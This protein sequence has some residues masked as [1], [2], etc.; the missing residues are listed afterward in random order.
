VEISAPIMG[1]RKITRVY[2]VAVP[3]QLL[4]SVGLDKET[5]VSFALSAEDP[6][7]ICMFAADAVELTPAEGHT[8][9]VKPQ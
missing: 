7:V 3:A 1:P 2:Q 4:R 5:H 6:R 8:H 9:T